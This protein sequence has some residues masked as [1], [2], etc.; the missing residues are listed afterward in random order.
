M[1]GLFP[2][3]SGFLGCPRGRPRSFDV[4]LAQVGPGEFEQF[5]TVARQYGPGGEQRESLDLLVADLGW[6]R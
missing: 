5:F 4:E 6:Q 2:F 3:W 1:T